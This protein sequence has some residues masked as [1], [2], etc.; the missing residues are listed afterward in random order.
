MSWFHYWSFILSPRL[1]CGI[2]G[3]STMV[4]IYRLISCFWVSMIDQ[5]GVSYVILYF[6]LVWIFD[7]S[8]KFPPYSAPSS[9]IPIFFRSHVGGMTN[10]FLLCIYHHLV[11][12]NSWLIQIW[13]CSHSRMFLSLTI[14]IYR[15]DVIGFLRCMFVSSSDEDVNVKLL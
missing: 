4:N 11:F 7:C 3:D 14:V 5:R 12:Q 15:N 8:Y 13:G 6:I 9:C 2:C 10:F 1:F